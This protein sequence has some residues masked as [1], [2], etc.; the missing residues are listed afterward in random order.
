M[1]WCG[2]AIYCSLEETNEIVVL[3]AFN[4]PYCCATMVKIQNLLPS[5]GF[6]DYNN[7]VTTAL[8]SRRNSKLYCDYSPASISRLKI[9]ILRKLSCSGGNNV[10]LEPD[11][12]HIRFKW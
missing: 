10:L 12:L 7:T 5:G 3:C 9:A 1:R 11:I 2:S 6:P 4:L 8:D